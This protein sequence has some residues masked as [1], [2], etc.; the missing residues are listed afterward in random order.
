MAMWR[1]LLVFI[2]SLKFGDLHQSI[3]CQNGYF[4]ANRAKTGNLSR[5]LRALPLLWTSPYAPAFGPVFGSTKGSTKIG[6][7]PTFRVRI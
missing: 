4:V 2:V 7:K 5:L 6:P 3:G 1:V